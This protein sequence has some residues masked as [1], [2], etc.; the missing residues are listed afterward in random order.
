M[1][2]FALVI[3]LLCTAGAT[4]EAPASDPVAG[5]VTALAKS[6]HCYTPRMPRAKLRAALATEYAEHRADAAYLSAGAVLELYQN[7]YR[8]TYTL[9]LVTPK[10]DACVAA[11]GQYAFGAGL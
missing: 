1:H 6:L 3:A 10:G 4:A 7:P 11:A 8:G 5:Y 9:V 2:K